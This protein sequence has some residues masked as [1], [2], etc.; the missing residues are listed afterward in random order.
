M[1]AHQTRRKKRKARPQLAH[2]DTGVEGVVMKWCEDEKSGGYGFIQPSNGA[3]RIGFYFSDIPRNRE[4]CT[5]EGETV[6]F[7]VVKKKNKQ[8][9][10]V[11]SG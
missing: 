3:P 1:H 2:G 6:F 9:K 8:L 5:G 11:I 4:K 10:A 7:R